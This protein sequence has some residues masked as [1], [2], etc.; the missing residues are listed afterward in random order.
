[1]QLGI[2]YGAMVCAMRQ[3][4]RRFC[5]LRFYDLCGFAAGSCQLQNCAS[6]WVR[7]MCAEGD[8]G[9]VRE[10]GVVGSGW[11]VRWSGSSGGSWPSSWEPS[12]PSAI[13]GLQADGR[14]GRCRPFAD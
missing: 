8:V 9:E 2:G 7:C 5:G 4:L 6:V 1:M 3:D 14:Q 12:A 11:R 10:T 13:R